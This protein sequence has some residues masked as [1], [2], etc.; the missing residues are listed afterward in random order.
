MFERRAEAEKA[1]N[2]FLTNRKRNSNFFS[3]ADY[4]PYSRVRPVSF[5]RTKEE[6]EKAAK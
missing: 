6:I 1:E 3:N 5:T 2:A 4:R